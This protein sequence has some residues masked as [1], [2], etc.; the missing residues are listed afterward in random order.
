[1]ILHTCPKCQM[2]CLYSV[3]LGD[4]VNCH[5]CGARF[6][7]TRFNRTDKDALT[8][9]VQSAHLKAQALRSSRRL[10][11]AAGTLAAL[12]VLWLPASILGLLPDEWRVV[13]RRF[14]SVAEESQ[15][16]ESVALVAVGSADGHLGAVLEDVFTGVAITNDGFLL[17]SQV[18]AR[19]TPFQDVWVFVAGRRYEAQV[20][21]AD[22]IADFA[23]IKIEAK[24]K[25]RFPIAR[26][27][28]I[29]RYNVP[30]V[31]IGQQPVE[32]IRSPMNWPLAITRGTI[33]RVF[34][35]DIGTEWIEHSA[36]IGERGR[37]G[38]LI[39]DDRVIGVNSSSDFGISRAVAIGGY[40]DRIWQ[41]I[42]TW[43]ETPDGQK[44]DKDVSEV[45]TK[46]TGIRALH[47]GFRLTFRT[48]VS[49]HRLEGAT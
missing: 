20:V 14:A 39:L 47:H 19:L 8:R 48:A 43:R 10:L 33:S 1:M 38:P 37:G 45:G 16:S 32:G 15:L 26:A 12:V 34:S 17:T 4:E 11:F 29:S 27:N 7:L 23:I 9:I 36:A 6:T 18:V 46:A 30:V 5:S 35:D 13:N 49:D 31:A 40:R 2:A 24:L 21:G 44:R 3:G 28:V 25:Y 42:R 22:K 41:M